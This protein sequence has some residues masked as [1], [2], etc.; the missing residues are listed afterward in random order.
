M[1]PAHATPER[2]RGRTRILLVEDN[3]V[4]RMLAVKLLE[5]TGYAVSTA[6]DGYSALQT[7]EGGS[8]DLILMDIQMRGMDGFE[9]PPRSASSSE[10]PE[11]TSP[12]LR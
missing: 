6:E 3:R 2:A 12:S 1:V 10:P 8:F 9:A 5:K 7:L 11:R 4:N